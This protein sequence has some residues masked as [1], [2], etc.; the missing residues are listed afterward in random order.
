M[1]EYDAKFVPERDSLNFMLL[2]FLYDCLIYR[3]KKKTTH[4]EI[5]YLKRLLD[6]I[7][8]CPAS[9]LSSVNFSHF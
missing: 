2:F 4:F 6:L 7:T 3:L 8:C 9:I 5:F 1:K